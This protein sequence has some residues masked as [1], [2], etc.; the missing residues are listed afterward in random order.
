MIDVIVATDK[1]IVTNEVVEAIV[2]NRANSTSKADE[3]NLAEANK[4]LANDGIAIV[5]YVLT[6]YC[7]IFAEV[8][9]C[10]GIIIDRSGRNN[11]LGLIL[12]I[13]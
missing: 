11:Q 13:V 6:K 5:L 8:K 10:F 4:L 3:A 1:A 7:E 9:G 2:I 12:A